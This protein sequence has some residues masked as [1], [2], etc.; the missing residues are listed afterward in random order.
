VERAT[1]KRHTRPPTP[2]TP[3]V[4]AAVAISLV[5]GVALL[6]I[7]PGRTDDLFAWTIRPDLTPLFMGSAYGAGAYFF[8]RCALSRSWHR[9]STAFLPIA[10]FAAL[11]L[12]ATLLHWDRFNRGDAPFVAATSFYL[13]VAIYVLSPLAVAGLWLRNRRAD[14]GAPEPVDAVVP[15]TVRAAA[16]VGGCAGVAAGLVAFLAPERF[17]DAWPW[18]LTPLTARVIGAFLVESGGI[19]VALARES[20]WSAWRLLVQTATIGA[21]LFGVGLV[22]GWDDLDLGNPLAWLLVGG[23]VLLVVAAPL[24][25]RHM[26]RTARASIVAGGRQSV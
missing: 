5:G 14:D 2:E 23:V 18:Q 16:A 19:A 15:R 10:L 9:S 13:W 11:M 6:W 4:C 25:H 3:W 22:R 17:A 1:A 21:L 24:F 7:A 8:V 12:I 26:D 20:R